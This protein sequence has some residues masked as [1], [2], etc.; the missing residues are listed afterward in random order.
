M[1][2][3]FDDDRDDA[4]RGHRRSESGKTIVAMA[5]V[6]ILFGVVAVGGWWGY[7]TFVG[8]YGPDYEGDGNGIAVQIEIASGE[9]IA[10]MGAKLEEADIVLSAQAFVSA[11]SQ[12]DELGSRIQPGIYQMEQ[13]MSAES[14]LRYLADP[15]NRIINGVTLPEGH[16]IFETFELLS[17]H[18]GLPV[19]DF[20]EAASDP[21]ARG[22][23]PLWFDDG[24]GG[25]YQL[26]IEGFLY[27]ATYEFPE[28]ATAEEILEQMVAHFNSQMEQM[29]FYNRVEAMDVPATP[30]AVLQVAAIIEGESGN[31]EDDP[32][33]ARV[34]YNRL[35][36]PGAIEEHGC[37]CLGTEA[38]WN[39]GNRLMGIPPIPSGDMDGSEMH[40]ESNPWAV[41]TRAN[42]GLAPTPIGSPGLNKLEGALEPTPG[43][44]WQY[45]VTAYPDTGLAIF[46][47]TYA[48]HQAGTDVARENGI[49]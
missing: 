16:R 14:A 5:A 6:I 35:Y 13:E 30:M 17:E 25:T 44:D 43:E 39:Y 20:E 24:E 11:A 22:V 2:D 28:G 9:S 27:P 48:E 29:D 37:N 26:S 34:M 7:K 15:A 32:R 3:K 42:E 10:Q 31:L 49:Q 40:D 4:P 47:D 1:L 21:I 36:H 38:V 46:S 33:I 19:E 41:S 45:F 12:N 23:D 8:G 18:T